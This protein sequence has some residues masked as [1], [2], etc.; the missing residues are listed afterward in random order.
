MNNFQWNKLVLVSMSRQLSPPPL[1]KTTVDMLEWSFFYKLHVKWW[2]LVCSLVDTI[3][4]TILVVVRK[5][6]QLRMQLVEQNLKPNFYFCLN[7]HVPL[8]KTSIFSG[9]QVK[10]SQIM[11]N[12]HIWR[13]ILFKIERIN[14]KDKYKF[15]R[16]HIMEYFTR[17]TMQKKRIGK[18]VGGRV[19][20]SLSIK[21]SLEYRL[22]LANNLFV[23]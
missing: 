1:P 13:F 19:T 21:W 5:I 4:I 3:K 18:T 9:A 14:S 7:Q 11:T 10:V 17:N 6:V 23:W 8:V 16:N 20:L 2:S 22:S 12:K 15:K